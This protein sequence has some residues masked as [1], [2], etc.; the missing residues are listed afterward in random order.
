M[1]DRINTLIQA[2]RRF[3]PK[4]IARIQAQIKA[5]QHEQELMGIP[6]MNLLLRRQLAE[7]IEEAFEHKI[8]KS[9]KPGERLQLELDV[10]VIP[11]DSINKVLDVKLNTANNF[12]EFI[13]DYVKETRIKSITW[14]NEM[15]TWIINYNYDV[16]C[17]TF[18]NVLELMEFIE[19]DSLG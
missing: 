14:D 16:E 4:E 1:S 7:K 2:L 11:T 19:I 15:G 9:T 3:Q 17:D 18:K 10:V 5:N 12:Q 13:D 6:Y 8:V